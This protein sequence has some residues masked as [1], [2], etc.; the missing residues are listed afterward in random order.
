MTATHFEASNDFLLFDDAPSLNHGNREV[1]GLKTNSARGIPLESITF[2]VIGVVVLSVIAVV[3]GWE[4]TAVLA[5]AMVA[6]A[7]VNRL[8]NRSAE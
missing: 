3:L 5:V 4:I 7:V 8:D 2:S 1:A 6:K